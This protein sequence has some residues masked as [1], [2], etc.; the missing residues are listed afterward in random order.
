MS[1]AGGRR[2]TSVPALAAALALAVM[3][4]RAAAARGQDFATPATPGA[5]TASDVLERGLPRADP[6][7]ALELGAVRWH[8]LAELT[9]RSA[10]GTFGW[11]AARVGLGLSQTGDPDLGWTALAAA[12][13]IADTSGGA[14]VRALARRDRTT[15]FGFDD[16]GAAVGAEVGA[17]GWVA[18][19]PRLTLWASA[20]QLWTAGEAPPLRR[21]LEIGA[22]ARAGGIVLWLTRAEI[23]GALRAARGEHAVGA[24]T[25]VGPLWIALGA[26]D[27][28][29]RGGLTVGA[30][31][32]PIGVAATVESH[33]LLGETVRLAL[34]VGR[35]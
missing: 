12:L 23:P 30:G 31:G 14:A 27:Q 8:G 35:R 16:S 7:P 28:P 21:G 32:H 33:P 29:L 15:A 19:A 11:R 4:G 2:A 13:G 10:A 17:G 22:L 34:R 18:V 26:R 3:V 6:A 20:P 9:T 25:A 5:T 1:A 24:G